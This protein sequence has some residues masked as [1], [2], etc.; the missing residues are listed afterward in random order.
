MRKRLLLLLIFVSPLASA[1]GGSAF[2]EQFDN[3]SVEQ[4]KALIDAMTPA[5]INADRDEEGQT[6]FFHCHHLGAT[7]MLLRGADSNIA[8]RA[9]RTP[10]FR[11]AGRAGD[12][13]LP[14]L[15][16]LLLLAHA[17]VNARDRDGITLLGWAAHEGNYAAV[18]LLLLLGANPAPADVPADRS[19]VFLASQQPNTKITDLLTSAANAR[20]GLDR[21]DVPDLA[22]AARAAQL[23][24]MSDALAAGADI[25]ARDEEGATALYRAVEERRAPVAALLLLKGANPNL[26][27]L[28]GRTPLIQCAGGF[29][30]ASERILMDLIVAG[31][32]VNAVAKDGTTALS[33]AVHSSSNTAAQ[34]MIWRGASLDVHSPDGT[35]MQGAALKANWPSMIELLKQAGLK[36]E[37]P[38][39]KIADP[40]IFD[41]ARTGTLADVEAELNK[42]TPADLA[43]H[44]DQTALEFAVCY[45]K[46]DVVGLLLRHGA[47]INRQ[48]SRSGESNMHGLAMWTTQGATPAIRLE[49]LVQLGANPDLLMR[50]GNTPLM[51]AARD[52]APSTTVEYLLKVTRNPNARNKDG[53]TALGLAREHGHAGTARLLADNGAVE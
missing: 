37:A 50:D 51:V 32:D 52:G 41:A 9:G 43:N 44:Y 17:D 18:K 19:P 42:G 45:D 4:D 49:K 29:D 20:P 33:Q 10:A 3:R 15:L 5:Q 40:A 38:V 12:F 8:N 26:A 24:E 53:L 36:E 25:N 6:A 34:W 31:A 13:R 14:M 16:D 21:R 35:L 2:L 47:D 27:K 11:A 48:H 28:D 30:M 46:W 39:A 7:L 1:Y 23:T 22:T